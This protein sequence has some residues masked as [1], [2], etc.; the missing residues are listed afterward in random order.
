MI[1]RFLSY[2][3]SEK[4]YSELTVRAYHDDIIM[5]LK[6]IDMDENHFSPE[7]IS[8]HDIREW[9]MYMNKQKASPRSINRRLSALKALYRYLRKKELTNNNPFVKISSLK[10]P[11]RLPAFI[12]ESKMEK[13]TEMMLDDIH[14]TGISLRD[15]LIVLL[16]YAS[17][18][19]LAELVNIREKDF[20]ADYSSLK[21]IG[22]GDKE[23]IVPIIPFVGEKIKELIKNNHENACFSNDN[24]LFL[25]QQGK[26][27]S[28]S[29]VYRT[30]RRIL[31]EGGVEGKTNPHI[32]RHTF[33]THLLNSGV[34]IRVI[35]E[36]L[37]HQSLM[38]TQVYTHN[39]IE[40]L[41][42]VYNIAHP[43]G[44]SKK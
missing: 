12:P 18:M 14:D 23:R 4:R 27:I 20:S 38:A 26:Q 11:K 9:I 35:Q 19:R 22:K 13:V 16:F 10:T 6:F 44:R 21:I 8:G 5:F 42:Q 3:R 2:L 37:G 36:L 1:E 30:V 33:A 41:K 32:L 25:N 31:K 39:N 29:G 24:F 34:D 28:R 17:G 43:R 15:E 40:Q 7:M